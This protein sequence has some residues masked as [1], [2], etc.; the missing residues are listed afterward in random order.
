[1]GCGDPRWQDTSGQLFQG[2]DHT[3]IVVANSAASLRFYRDRLGMKVAGTSENWGT[4]QEH[5]NNVFGARLRITALRAARGPGVE[6]LE[7][8]TPR[9]GRPTPL[10]SRANDLWHWQVEFDADGLAARDKVL[11]ADGGGAV[12]AHAITLPDGAARMYRDSDGHA[13]VLYER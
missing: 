7:Y 5:L 12:S 4:E 11:G 3:A 9:D 6:L 10:D 13:I 8:L 2:I 1:M